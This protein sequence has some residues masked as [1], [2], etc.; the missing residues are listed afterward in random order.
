ML[1]RSPQMMEVSIARQTCTCQMSPPCNPNK[2]QGLSRPPVRKSHHCL[3]D[4]VLEFICPEYLLTLEGDYMVHMPFIGIFYFTSSVSSHL[5]H[6]NGSQS[7]APDLTSGSPTPAEPGS[8][9]HGTWR[10]S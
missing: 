2:A 10:S 9:F 4:T 1:K 3:G 6:T 7:R 5:L 8:A